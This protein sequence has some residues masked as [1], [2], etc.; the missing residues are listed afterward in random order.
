MGSLA[1]RITSRWWAGVITAVAVVGAALV[2]GLIGTATHA[3]APTDAL[4]AGSDSAAAAQLAERLPT[5]DESTAIVLFTADQ[6]KLSGQDVKAIT[7]KMASLDNA[8]PNVQASKDG[9]AAIGVV[10]V[11]GSDAT[12]VADA[13]KQLRAT[14][15]SDLPTGVTAQVTGPAGIQADLAAVFDGANFRLLLSTATVVAILLVITYRSPI[16]W[17]IPLVVVGL[18][19]QVAASAATHTLALIHIP[20]DESTVGILSVLVFGAGTDYALLLISRYRDELK[21]EE[22][23]RLALAHSL[24]R[25]VEAVLASATT[26][27]V[28]LLTLTLSAFPTTRGLGVACAVGVLVAAAFVLIV[29]P[30]VLS[31]FGRWIFW[32]KVPHVGDSSLADGHSAWRRVGDAV[33]KRPLVYVICGVIVLGI[34]AAGATSIKTGLSD[35]DQFLKK[36]EAIAASQRLAQS[37]PAG[38][39][40]PT[41]VVTTNDPKRVAQT[42][43]DV[44]GV[45]SVRP[46]ATGDG[47]AQLSVTLDAG[48]GTT[49]AADTVVAIR[50]AVRDLPTTNVGGPEAQA[51]DSAQAASRDRLVVIPVI[52]ALVLLALALLLRAVVAPI[53]LVATVVLTYLSSLGISWWLFQHVF[54]F[55]ALDDNA[56][57]FAFVFLVALG[58]DYNI[59]LVTRAREETRQ[60]GTHEGMIRALAATGGVI[61]SAGILLAAVFAVLG[62]LPLVVLAQLGVI[63]FVGVLIDTLLVRTILVPAIALVAGDRFW[64]PSRPAEAATEPEPSQERATV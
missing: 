4:A 63:I 10:E 31:L 35:A 54:G 49:Q 22:D 58:V 8:A 43:G 40:N 25:T 57:L 18:A 64:W 47:V 44:D 55:N 36:P 24:R 33:A 53:A 60:H 6:G 46:G 12:A 11:K 39:S 14:V 16:L 21:H 41:L 3:T 28:G 56:P 34:A 51:L 5:S 62:V 59:F 2:I 32:P 37:F 15:K 20:W 7:A 19:D 1:E 61:T 38:S 26:V 42:V 45:A 50:D 17:V 52:L 9:T 23:R 30:A 27:F 48:S 29:L 13:V